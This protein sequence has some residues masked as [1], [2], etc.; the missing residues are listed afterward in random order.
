MKHYYR[1][2]DMKNG[3]MHSLFHKTNG[4]KELPLNQW[5]EADVKLVRDGS[6]KT[7]T[8]YTG[9]WHVFTEFEE[10]KKFLL[11]RFANLKPKAI[12]KCKVK[13]IWKKEH[14]RNNILLV[15]HMLIE[16]IIWKYE[17]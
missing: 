1:F 10:T 9:G 17:G 14:S 7:S 2:V 11:K 12:V 15:R 16:K 8:E 13:D 3:K 5:I 6:R 4:T